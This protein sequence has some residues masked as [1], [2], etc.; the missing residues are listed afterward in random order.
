MKSQHLNTILAAL[1]F[2]Q[3]EGLADSPVKR[4]DGI[5]DIATNGDTDI[6][7]DSD[8]IDELCELLNVGHVTLDAGSDIRAAL[9][10][11]SRLLPYEADDT[12][13][14]P[15]TTTPPDGEDAMRVL[16]FHIL[17]ARKVLLENPACH[18]PTGE[19]AGITSDTVRLA[20][21][22]HIISEVK[23][24]NGN[25]EPDVMAACLSKI[26]RTFDKITAAAIA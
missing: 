18:P 21:I 9:E 13:H 4:G 5:H 10:Q 22:L 26:Q 11:V 16:N 17:N 8:G 14:D 23:L 7:L 19:G 1:R 25:S 2:Y 3:E 12:G 20:K 24:V 6:S 15:E